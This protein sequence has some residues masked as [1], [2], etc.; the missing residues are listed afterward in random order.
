MQAS[1]QLLLLYCYLTGLLVGWLASKLAMILAGWPTGLLADCLSYFFILSLTIVKFSF[2]FGLSIMIVFI[3]IKLFSDLA[4]D[5]F[6]PS[7]QLDGCLNATDCL[8]R[9]QLVVTGKST[10]TGQR[11]IRHRFAAAPCEI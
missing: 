5:R 4:L 7:E 6:T 2:S 9:S 11:L 8:V 1:A 3:Y 10:N